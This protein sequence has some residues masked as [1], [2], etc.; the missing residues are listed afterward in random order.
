MEGRKGRRKG[1]RPREKGGQKEGEGGT[2]GG[3]EEVS[4]R[5]GSSDMQQGSPGFAE[6]VLRVQK[7]SAKYLLR[8][9]S[10]SSGVRESFAKGLLR[11]FQNLC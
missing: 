10:R 5:R 8:S 1:A 3:R 6:G 11:I 7:G 4:L 9:G 2:K